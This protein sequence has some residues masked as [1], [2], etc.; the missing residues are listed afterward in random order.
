MNRKNDDGMIFLL[1]KR[2]KDDKMTSSFKL[3]SI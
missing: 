1:L 3:Y 2:E